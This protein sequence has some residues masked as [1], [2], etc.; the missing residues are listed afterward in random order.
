MKKLLLFCIV[1]LYAGAAIANAEEPHPTLAIGSPAPNFE[2]PGVDGEI[3][4]LSDYASA[5]VLVVVF[6]CD[7]CPIAQ[8][9]E[10][11]IKKLAAD[12]QNQGVA[13]VAIQPNDPSA[14]RIDELDC[15]DMSDSIAEM[16]IRAKYRHFNFPYLYDGATQSVADAYGPKATPHIFIFDAQRILR[17]EGRIDNSYRK[18]LVKTEDARNA[19]DALLA[20]KPPPVAHTGVFGCSTKWKYKRESRL[21]DEAR[22]NAEP[23]NV[24]LANA[25]EL[26]KLRANPTGKYLLVNFW[27]TG[28]DACVRRLA[29]LIDTFRMYLDRD[30]EFVSVSTNTPDEESSVL[31]VLQTRHASNRNLL[32]ASNNTGELQKAFDPDWKSG[33]PFTVLL[34]PHG[35]VLYRKEGELNVLDLRRHILASMPADYAGFQKYWTTP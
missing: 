11:R 17:Y 16:K 3:H 12:Y 22:I 5:K 6:T 21:A 26:K 15:S 2:L 8:L 9:Y 28:C 7:H 18:E 1:T 20:D 35:D 31:K 14:I 23:V 25:N 27:A 33:V 13:L 34:S 10:D 29:D 4:K 30:F 32:F 19:I 24:E